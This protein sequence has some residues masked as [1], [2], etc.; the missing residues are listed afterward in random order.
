MAITFDST[1]RIFSISTPAMSY[2]FYVDPGGRVNH[3][4]WGPVIHGTSS[5][6]AHIAER[7][8]EIA[9]MTD[10]HS[11][12]SRAEYSAQEPHEYEP[13]ALLAI[14]S[15]GVRDSRLR[16]AGH[17]IEGENLVVTLTDTVYPL[18]V[19]LHYQTWKDLD[20][21]SRKAVIRNG[22]DKPVTLEIMKSAVFYLPPDIP[23]RLTYYTGQ[24]GAEYQKQRTMIGHAGTVLENHRGTCGAHQA[25]PFFCVDPRGESTETAGEVYFGALHWSGNFEIILRQSPEGIVSIGGGTGTHDTNWQLGPSEFFE[26]P[27]F[28]A[29]YSQGGFEGMSKTLYDWQYDHLIPRSKAY[30]ERPVI[31]NSWYPYL[32]D[33]NEE[34]ILG[35]IDKAADMGVDLFVIDDGW[36]EGRSNDKKGLGDWYVDTKRFPRGFAPIIEACRKRDMLFGLWVEPEMVNPDSDLYRAHPDW[37]IHDPARERSESRNQLV[38]NFARED[39]YQFAIEMLD[40]L[41]EA[42]SLDYLK[43]DMNRY[44]GETGWPDAPPAVRRSLPIRYIQNLYRVW[45]HLNDKY[46]GVLYENCAGGGG[47]SDFGMVPF[48]DRCNRSDNADPVDLMRVHEGFTTI[49]I[50]KFAGGAGNVSPSPNNI[51]GRVTPLQYRIDWGMTGSMSIGINLLTAPKDELE[52]LR[53]ALAEFKTLRKDLQDSY[54]Y[55]ILSSWEGP[56]AAFQYLK[57]DRSAFTLFVFGHGLH[58]RQHPPLL[59]MRSLLPDKQYTSRDGI[60]MTGEA[61]MNIGISVSLR[62]DYAS[63]V[64]TFR[65]SC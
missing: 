33:I 39:V 1:G 55:R 37:V 61:L 21:I 54:V 19:D 14:Y 32:F 56:F 34:N 9:R 36:M 50:P 65:L 11:G 7:N 47:R 64:I 38:L 31:Y 2:L 23:W 59:R 29:G 63:R 24:W 20:L 13:P 49:F 62:G 53:K 35:L 48:T 5:F 28:T 60:T 27:L 43:W 42:Y 57:R 22:G 17:K 25:V 52:I 10:H 18:S 30:K 40:R 26:T 8:G 44:F 4:Y 3:L 45:R 12:S 16:Y 46:P 51:N 58:Y 15:D 6:D 41:M